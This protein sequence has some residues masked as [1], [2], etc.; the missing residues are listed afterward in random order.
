M[1]YHDP[2]HDRQQYIIKQSGNHKFSIEPN[3]SNHTDLT[4]HPIRHRIEPN[5]C[6]AGGINKYQVVQQNKTAP[7]VVIKTNKSA[8]EIKVKNTEIPILVPLF[9]AVNNMI[10]NIKTKTDT[11]HN[12]LTP[13]LAQ[14]DST[15]TDTLKPEEES[16]DELPDS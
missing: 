15:E 14:S 16:S 9:L 6:E 8:N 2:S 5:M 13:V 10:D 1:E 4:K 12:I 7:I 11:T 3:F